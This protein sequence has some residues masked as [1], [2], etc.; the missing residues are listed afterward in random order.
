MIVDHDLAALDFLADLT[1]AYLESYRLA[2]E[3]ALE[4]EKAGEPLDRRSLVKLALERGRADFLSGHLALQESLSKATLE[5]AFEWLS[6]QGAFAF[7]DGRWGLDPAWR[8]GSLTG[9]V[10][11]MS[12]LMAVK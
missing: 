7:A 5:N 1:R 12:R 4:A 11:E 2:A 9:L 6:G 10:H 3:T 8:D